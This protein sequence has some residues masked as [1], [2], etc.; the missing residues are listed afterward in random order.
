MIFPANPLRRLSGSK[1]GI[2]FSV[3]GARKNQKHYKEFGNAMS[4]EHRDN[5]HWMQHAIELAKRAEQEGEVPVGAI[6]VQDDE[7]IGEGW[8][9]PI[10]SG[11]PTGHAEIIALRSAASLINNYRLT[12]ADLYVTLEPCVM[13]AGAIIH[14]RISR[15]IFGAFDPKAG[16]AGS[17][18]SVLG[19]DKLNHRVTVTSGVMAEE[20]A[21]ILQEFFRKKR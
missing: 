8:N 16:A 6:V 17:L 9:R 12:G 11:D 15:V 7:I 14:A 2:R 10:A 5:N 13:C 20:C 19:T 3:Y 18:F 4:P 21:T 1:A